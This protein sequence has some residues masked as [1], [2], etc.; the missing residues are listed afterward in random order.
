MDFDKELEKLNK[1]WG[2][3]RPGAGAKK[4]AQIKVTKSFSLSRKAVENLKNLEVQ[5]ELKS[6]SQVIEYLLKNAPVRQ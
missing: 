1:K 2:G 3:F 5:L 4:Q 6:Q